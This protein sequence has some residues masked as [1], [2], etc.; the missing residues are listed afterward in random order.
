MADGAY[1]PIEK[2][3]VGDQVLSVSLKD[4]YE[5]VAAKVVDT[6]RRVAHKTINLVLR[7]GQEI[8]V[9]PGHPFYVRGQGWR[10]AANLGR[11][12]VL[13]AYHGEGLQAVASAEKEEAI[14]VYNLEVEP[15]H[16]YLITTNRILVHNGCA[17]PFFRNRPH[18]GTVT[19]ILNTKTG[20][21]LCAES[22]N[23]LHMQLF[24]DQAAMRS[25]LG[26]WVGGFAKFSNGKLISADLSSATFSGTQTMI[27]EAMRVIEILKN[28]N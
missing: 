19:Y 27:N 1:K 4:G 2:V 7:D 25:S 10:A 5:V 6:H 12:D 11:D 17:V 15:Q 14:E 18:N 22:E 26:E 9:T 24:M 21:F 13:W 3:N 16:N 28:T 20:E 8:R 23:V